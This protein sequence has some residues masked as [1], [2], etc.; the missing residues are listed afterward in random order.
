L[1]GRKLLKLNLRRGRVRTDAIRLHE[2]QELSRD[3]LQRVGSQFTGRGVRVVTEWDELDNIARSVTAAVLQLDIVAVQ[4]VHVGEISI[5]DTDNDDGERQVA[6]ID[7]GLDRR[8]HVSNFT[9]GYDEKN[10]VRLNVVF[11]FEEFLGAFGGS[12]DGRRE[13]R[14]SVKSHFLKSTVIMTV[15]LSPFLMIARASQSSIKVVPVVDVED[16]LYAVNLGIGAQSQ[17]E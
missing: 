1:A 10:Q 14:R 7:N 6:G 9:V 13:I 17:G 3:L 5:S 8:V 4:S 15:N 2:L 12:V 16:S 11:C